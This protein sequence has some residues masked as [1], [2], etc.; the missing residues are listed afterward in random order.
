VAQDFAIFVVVL[1]KF[2][3]AALAEPRHF[4]GVFIGKKS[5][6]FDDNGSRQN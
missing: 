5:A 1:A 3:P 2:A 4:F 6:T